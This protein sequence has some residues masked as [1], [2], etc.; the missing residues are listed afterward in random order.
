MLKIIIASDGS[1]LVHDMLFAPTMER[2][3]Y[4]PDMS[5]VQMQYIGNGEYMNPIT[6]E[7]YDFSRG[8]RVNGK[9]WGGGSIN[10]QTN[11]DS[12]FLNVVPRNPIMFKK[13][14]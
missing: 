1:I 11:S 4:C 2:S 12:P 9:L 5:G 13:E 8:V 6:G 7:V 10:E 14:I 3:R